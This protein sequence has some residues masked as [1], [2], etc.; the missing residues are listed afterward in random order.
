[1]KHK[2]FS[3]K[4]M[5]CCL[6]KVFVREFDR[7]DQTVLKINQCEI[8]DVGCVVWDAA[9]VLTSYLDSEHFAEQ[10]CLQK[11]RVV[12]VGSG[13]GICGLQAACLG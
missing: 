2:R 7:K 11:A 13:T 5:T 6:E 8:G 9:L 3:D 1:M 12:E 10:N 4:K